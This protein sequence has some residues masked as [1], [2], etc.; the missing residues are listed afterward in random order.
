MPPDNPPTQIGL[1]LYPAQLE[2]LDIY[3]KEKGLDR[4]SAIRVAINLLIDGTAP[5]AAPAAPSALSTVDQEARDALTKLATKVN[6]LGAVQGKH[7]ER[8]NAL[9]EAKPAPAPFNIDI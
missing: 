3:C 5:A 9:E 4:T 2:A 1:R 6:L 8:L 7:Q